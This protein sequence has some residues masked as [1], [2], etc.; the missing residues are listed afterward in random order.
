MCIPIL[1]L[2]HT[3]QKYFDIYYYRKL[4][5]GLKNKERIIF[6]TTI[7]A[8]PVEQPS[9]HQHRAVSQEDKQKRLQ[10]WE[11]VFFTTE[12][13]KLEFEKKFEKKIS[14]ND[15]ELYMSWLSLTLGAV[16]GDNIT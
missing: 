3:F 16:G 9:L 7:P 1:F 4:V 14:D 12:A 5:I 8:S 15:N 13:Q 10:M 2:A 6:A 11:A